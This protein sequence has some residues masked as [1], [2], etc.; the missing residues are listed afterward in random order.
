MSRFIMG[1][2]VGLILG[3]SCG[4]YAAVIAGSGYLLGW[5]VMKDGE[6]ICSAPYVWES[7]REIECD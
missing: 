7:I 2:L 5:S 4:A 6:E 1:V 3:M